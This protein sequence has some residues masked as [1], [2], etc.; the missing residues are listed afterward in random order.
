MLKL[1]NVDIGYQNPLIQAINTEL[2]LG[3]VAL[4]IG[5]NGVGKTTLIKSILGQIPLLKGEISLNNKNI[6]TLN[7][8]EIA[9]NIAIVF[10]KANV[11]NNYTTKD[12][13]SLGKFIH[14]PYYF[15]LNSKDN[16]EIDKIIKSLDLYEYKD[17][18]L[19][20]LSDGNLQKAFIGR[21]LAQNSPI[22]ILD[23]PTTHLDEK[24]KKSILKIL[25]NLAKQHQKLILF[26]SH[27]WRLAKD[28]S[29]KIWFIKDKQL[30]AGLTEDILLEH[31]ELS[32]PFDFQEKTIQ[33]PNIIA[34]NFEKELL[35]TALLKHFN[36]DLS[37]FSI[38]FSENRWEISHLGKNTFTNSLQEIID[39]I[40]VNI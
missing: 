35:K 32:E 30:Y 10:S 1:K 12:L 29:D 38:H 19:Q 33:L 14:Y 15:Q 24:N 13:V 21:A 9:E 23:E 28:F 2:H 26:S 34:P 8:K 27:D 22:I 36:K 31:R 17:F 18:P 6:K 5:N 20:N 25:K 3:E 39:F 11:P 37:Q 7:N 4:I 16:A 40:K